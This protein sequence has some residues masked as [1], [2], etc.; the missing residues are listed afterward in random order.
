MFL[1]A[2]F[3]ELIKDN[4]YCYLLY[5]FVQTRKVKIKTNYLKLNINIKESTMLINILLLVLEILRMLKIFSNT[6][7]KRIGSYT[8]SLLSDRQR[9]LYWA[10]RQYFL[11][12]S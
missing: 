4:K 8:P 12:E 11:P 6:I 2:N 5:Y 3:R 9:G 7:Q 1:F 10:P